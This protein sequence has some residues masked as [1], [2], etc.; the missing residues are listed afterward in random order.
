[1]KAQ[2]DRHHGTRSRQ[3]RV[4][5]E[6]TVELVNGAQVL[7]KILR[8]VLVRHLNQL[9]RRSG[10]VSAPNLQYDSL[11]VVVKASPNE[12]MNLSGISGSNSVLLKVFFLVEPL[13]VPRNPARFQAI[14]TNGRWRNLGVPQGFCG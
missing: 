12:E 1:M 4:G 9:W 7:P 8:I 5:E 10:E 6:V 3:F 14:G 13:G 11:A 2:F